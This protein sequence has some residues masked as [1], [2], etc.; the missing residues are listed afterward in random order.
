MVAYIDL[1]F[2]ENFFMNY[3]TLFTTA[4]LL[5]RR[6]KKTR[7]IIASLMGAL[8]VFTLFFDISN[9]SLNL[10]KLVMGI[11]LLAIS[12][13]LKSFK[14]L[15]KESLVFFMITFVYAGCALGFIYFMK[16][17]I[18]YIV[19]GIIIGGEYIFEIVLIS[20]V[21]SY[22]LI[23][24]SIKLIKIKQKFSKKQMLCD[25]K[26]KNGNYNI[27]VKA[28][29]DTGNLL[30]DPISKSPVIIVEKE[31][32]RNL[33]S[34]SYFKKLESII[35]GDEQETLNDFCDANIKMIPYMSVGE[36]NGMMLAYK[37]EKIKFEYQYELYEIED[38]LIGFYD[39]ALTN[40][41]KYSALVGLQIFERS[42]EKN[43]YNAINKNQSKYS[44]C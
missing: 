17:K 25:L 8:Y 36:K 19:N 5:N 41:G 7:I 28:L 38:V 40:N 27:N 37:I 39:N 34:K 44:V 13:G 12:F 35:G 10:L 33:F 1:I 14:K 30:T 22:L 21:I 32:A 9:L 15:L 31:K 4:K 26:I 24:A 29:I 11:S 23:K 43:E 2:L 18:I 6:I 16:P 3:L 20:A 42:M